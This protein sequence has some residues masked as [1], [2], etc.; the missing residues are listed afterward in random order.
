MPIINYLRIRSEALAHRPLMNSFIAGSEVLGWKFV[1]LK[2]VV[3]APLLIQPI[4]VITRYLVEVRP[5]RR[6]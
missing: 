3:V 2:D 6:K 4:G 5:I 1:P